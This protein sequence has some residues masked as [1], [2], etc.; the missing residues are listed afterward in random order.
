MDKYANSYS[1]NKEVV[2]QLPY[3]E[4]RGE[5]IENRCGWFCSATLHKIF[6]Y[7]IYDKLI[8]DLKIIRLNF[9]LI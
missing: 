7:N 8:I 1:L 4:Y 9:N 3:L 6:N 5:S 2:S